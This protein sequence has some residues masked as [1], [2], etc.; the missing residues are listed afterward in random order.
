MRSL[1]QKAVRAVRRMLD[2]TGTLSVF[3]AQCKR[4]FGWTWTDRQSAGRVA[5]WFNPH[6]PHQLPIE[7]AR[8]AVGVS[9]LDYLSPVF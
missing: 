2:E 5:Q 1:D 4:S 6:D 3:V 9:G 8:I 7:A